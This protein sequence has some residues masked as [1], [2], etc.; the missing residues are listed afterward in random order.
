[1]EGQ[2]LVKRNL[3]RLGC[4]GRWLSHDDRLHVATPKALHIGEDSQ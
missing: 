4:W 1:M 3:R 2:P